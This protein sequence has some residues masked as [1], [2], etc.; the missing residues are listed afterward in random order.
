MKLFYIFSITVLLFY[1]SSILK[2]SLLIC[3]LVFVLLDKL[4]KEYGFYLF[5]WLCTVLLFLLFLLCR[6]LYIHIF[7]QLDC[8]LLKDRIVYG[9]PCILSVKIPQSPNKNTE[10]I[11]WIQLVLYLSKDRLSFVW[12]STR[13]EKG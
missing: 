9:P 8:K 10:Q 2:T 5:Y 11:T 13:E 1:I 3:T 7:S 6:C 4:D 12:L